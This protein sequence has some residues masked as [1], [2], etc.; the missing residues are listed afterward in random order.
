VDFGAKRV[1]KRGRPGVVLIAGLATAISLPAMAVDWPEKKV[2]IV[3]QSAI[4][5]LVEKVRQQEAENS[6]ALGETNVQTEV[7]CLEHISQAT[8]ILHAEALQ[9]MRL[10]NV[11]A[12][13]VNPVDEETVV[14]QLY[15]ELRDAAITLRLAR[16]FVSG[17]EAFCAK[18]PIV[19]DQAISVN[20]LLDQFEGRVRV[21]H[22]RIG[23]KRPA[24]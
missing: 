3:D 13:I 22:E 12:D 16:M 15:D 21:L 20:A 10:S 17:A 9:N 24:P 11:A 6:K 14:A 7:N 19:L 5:V 2:R 4:M 18:S 1:T 23:N 8:M